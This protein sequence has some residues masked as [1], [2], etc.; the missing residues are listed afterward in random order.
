MTLVPSVAMSNHLGLCLKHAR[1]SDTNL[2]W[3]TLLERIVYNKVIVQ[4]MFRHATPNSIMHAW[5]H[6]ANYSLEQTTKI[7][8]RYVS[9]HEAC[10]ESR[11]KDAGRKGEGSFWSC[12]KVA[13]C[14]E[15]LS[16][17]AL[18]C[19]ARRRFS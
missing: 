18:A 6:V 12:C 17:R 13:L 10:G 5:R 3:K 1:G 19:S 7:G 11:G 14:A 8:R 9:M 16:C 15:R 2:R 4:S